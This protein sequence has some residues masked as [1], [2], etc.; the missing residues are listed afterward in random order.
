LQNCR[1]SVDRVG[2]NEISQ[3]NV[4]VFLRWLIALTLVL[5][6]VS[7]PPRD[8]TLYVIQ[9]LAIGVLVVVNL[10]CS[11]LNQ[12]SLQR[13]STHPL[14]FLADFGLMTVGIL[15]VPGITEGVHL[16]YFL[17]ILIGASA[18][19]LVSALG[20]TAVVACGYF[21]Y[22]IGLKGSNR[23]LTPSYLLCPPFLLVVVCLINLISTQSRR[24]GAALQQKDQV[25]RQT[26]GLLHEKERQYEARRI[27][28]SAEIERA[29]QRLA[30]LN[31][32]NRNIL[33]SVNTGIIITDLTGRVKTCNRHA[34]G[35]LDLDPGEVLG[36]P[37]ADLERLRA[38][39]QI[40]ETALHR[41]A[42]LVR[43]EADVLKAGDV[44]VT[45]GVG[46][47]LLR[48]GAGN[49]TGV[50][51][52]FQDITPI[53]SLRM[54]LAQS[55][56]MA[57]LGRLSADVA[58]EVRNPLNSIRGFSQ[59][60]NEATPDDS[61]FHEY[62]DIIMG[63]VDRLSKFLYNVL[64]FARVSKHACETLDLWELVDEALQLARS[65][66][67]NASVQIETEHPD[68]VSCA[69]DAEKLE[70]VFLNMIFNAVEAM[71]PGGKLTIRLRSE[72]AP[73]AAVIEFQD[74]G[75]GMTESQ[76]RTI[77]NPFVTHK[78]DGVGLGLSIS[79]Q[80]VESHGGQI[81]VESSIGEGTTFTV[82]LPTEA[83][84]AARN[85]Q[86][87]ES[88]QDPDVAGNTES[89]TFARS[90]KG[91]THEP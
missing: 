6:L 76:M 29:H 49:M 9:L 72:S 68:T 57:A 10:L 44:R 83:G 24:L 14:F 3:R 52:F 2:E 66:I 85:E 62:T 74:T 75:C 16:L 19:S 8:V 60:I 58:H 82:R 55:E 7:T 90:L 61:D 91:E 70:R 43:T 12:R 56:K 28:S 65:K 20:M 53:K 23:F 79:N 86:E 46:V 89:A 81:S 1:H 37:L 50:I 41:R 73:P 42:A 26:T 47:S 59:L 48:N 40:I 78:P 64:D 18:P 33:Q 30:E 36:R 51:A 4:L 21:A 32:Y 35:I 45:L 67:S 17:A 84:P 34:A 5:F 39:A 87:T 54:E 71:E 69:G 77:F 38:L 15:L 22:D 11:L 27:R 13:W 25:L 88:H 80:I 31:E 63:E